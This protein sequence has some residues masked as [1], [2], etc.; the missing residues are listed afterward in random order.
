MQTGDPISLDLLASPV[1][2]LRLP[3]ATLGAILVS[4]PTLLVFLRHLG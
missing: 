3:A 1:E 2:G 4:G